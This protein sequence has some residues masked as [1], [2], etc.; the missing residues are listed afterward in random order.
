MTKQVMVFVMA[1]SC[2]R[3]G[4]Q[5]AKIY[6]IRMIVGPGHKKGRSGEGH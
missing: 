3:F 6:E 2:W 5:A 1:Q 4:H